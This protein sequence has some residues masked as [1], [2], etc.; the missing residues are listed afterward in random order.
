MFENLKTL[1]LVSSAI[2]SLLSKF[3]QKNF[4]ENL[5]LDTSNIYHRILPRINIFTLKKVFAVFPNVSSQRICSCSLLDLEP[6]LNPI[7]LEIPDGRK[8]LKTLCAYVKLDNLSLTFCAIELVLNECIGLSEVSLLIH[9][10]FVGEVS[11][12]FISM[13]MARWPKLKW[14]WRIWSKG[15]EDC[16]RDYSYTTK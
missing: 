12:T 8:R 7:H 5:T 2:D 1:V 11:E 6:S 13:C 16:W 14:R 10:V 4:V 3:P 15:M 9:T